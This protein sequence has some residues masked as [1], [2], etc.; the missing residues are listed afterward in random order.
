MRTLITI[1]LILMTVPLSA[2]TFYDV[3]AFRLELSSK[4]SFSDVSDNPLKPFGFAVGI[5]VKQPIETDGLFVVTPG[6]ALRFVLGDTRERLYHE[7]AYAH[8]NLTQF[9]IQPSIAFGWKSSDHKHE[10]GIECTWYN[11]LVGQG[12]ERWSRL[13]IERRFR[14]KGLGIAFYTKSANFVFTI[15]PYARLDC[16]QYGTAVLTSISGTLDY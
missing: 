7:W 6:V 12:F 16:G 3:S 8:T 9:T 13:N 1:Y 5:G 11:L 10:T 4:A 2:E 14:A 15:T